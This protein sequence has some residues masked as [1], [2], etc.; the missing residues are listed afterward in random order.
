MVAH[1]LVV[2]VEWRLLL[3]MWIADLGLQVGHNVGQ[4]LEKLSLGL[5]KLLHGRA[6]V[7]GLNDCFSLDGSLLVDQLRILT[8]C[9]PSEGYGHYFK[10]LSQE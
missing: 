6:V 7:L 9:S 5:E 2:L 8:W 4:V 3:H 10:C 1:E